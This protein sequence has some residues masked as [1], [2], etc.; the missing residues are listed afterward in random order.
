M[1]NNAQEISTGEPSRS[2]FERSELQRRNP[3]Y[4]RGAPILPRQ[5]YLSAC[6]GEGKDNDPLKFEG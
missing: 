6:G 2:L 4:S 1:W 5:S 3:A